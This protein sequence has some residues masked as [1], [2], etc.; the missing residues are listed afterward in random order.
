MLLMKFYISLL[1]IFGLLAFS[2]FAVIGGDNLAHA[3]SHTPTVSINSTTVTSPTN[4]DPI[5]FIVRFSESITGFDATDITRSSGTVQDFGSN[6]YLTAF[7]VSPNLRPYNVA[8][9]STDHVYTLTVGVRGTIMDVFDSDD[10]R[11]LP[12]SIIKSYGTAADQL[13]LPRSML[14]D[15]DGDIYIT[16][17]LNARVQ[18]FNSNFQYLGQFG[19]RGIAEDN[20]RTPDSIAINSTGHIFVT[21]F[22]R[23]LVNIFT[24]N[25]NGGLY[26]GKIGG[27]GNG[28]ATGE[29]NGPRGI[30]IDSDDIIYIADSINDRVQIFNSDGTYQKSIGGA[31]DSIAD[32]E[33]NAPIGIALDS[34]NNIYVT[35]LINDRIQVFNSDG[36]YQKKI[37]GVGSS[38]ILGEFVD[39]RGI[40]V[41]SDGDVY[42]A[43]SRNERFQKLSQTPTRYTFD[44]AGPTDQETLTVSIPAGAAQDTD[45]NDN[46]ISNVISLD[47][48]RTAPTVSSAVTTS[49][50][51]VVLTVSESVSGTRI[52]A[53][54]FVIANVGS[55][56]TV[57]AVV[58][59][60]TTI[61]LTLSAA[62]SE[63]DAAPTVSYTE[64]FRTISDG[65][66]NTI[67]TFPA[68]S[69]TNNIDA[70]IPSVILSSDVSGAT[71]AATISFVATFSEN[72]SGFD[73]SDITI[74]SGTIQNL[75]PASPS[76]PAELRYTFDVVN[77]T[78]QATL[79]VS[80]PA[81]AA[82]DIGPNDSTASNTISLDIDR[83]I[84]T[85]TSATVA[86]P[87]SVILEISESV[88]G[89]N[90]TPGDF[91]ISG[92]TTPTIVSA[93]DITG[94]TITLTLS[95]AIISSDLPTLS[96]TATS[97]PI[98]DAA[99][100]ALAAFS[101]Q[102]ITN[103]LDT[104]AP[105]I[106]SA[107]VTTQTSVTL[108]VSESVSGTNV[109]PGDFTISS[110][111]TPTV[112]SGVDIT[113][114]TITLTLSVAIAD[115]D[116]PTVSY[117]PTSNPISDVAR[118]TLA[119]FS[120]QSVTNDLDTTAPAV[121]SVYP[122]GESS[123]EIMITEPVIAVGTV[124]P[125]S[126]VVTGINPPLTVTAVNFT[127]DTGRIITLTLSAPLVMPDGGGVLL[128]YTA[129]ANSVI[130]DI[131][132]NRFAS[133]SDTAV[134]T[135]PIITLESATTNPTNV[136]PIPF[137]ARVNKAVAGFSAGDITVSGVDSQQQY[138]HLQTIGTTGVPGTA[139]GQFRNPR[140]IMQ[141]SDGNI[142]V[143][144]RS[145]HRIQIFD[146]DTGQYVAKFGSSGS[147][148]GQLHLPSDIIQHTNSNIYVTDSGNDRVQV[149]DGTTHA[150]IS[151]FGSSGIQ[152]GEFSNPGRI[153]QHTNGN[154][155]VTDFEANRVQIFNGTTH[156]YISQFGSMGSANGQFNTP[157][158]IKQHP[159]GN[160]YIVDINNDR[161]QIF[162]GTTHAYISQ[163]GSVGSADGEF[164]A[165]A[166]ILHNSDGD[167]YV[168]DG[169]NHNIQVFDGT[170]H[171]YKDQFGSSGSEDGQFNFPIAMIQHTN[172]NIYVTGF[173]SHRVQIFTGSAGTVQNFTTTINV[174]PLLELR[175]ETIANGGGGVFNGPQQ[176]AL[177]SAG[178][179]YVPDEDNDQIQIFDA[180]GVF[181]NSF[182]ES[183][184][185]DGQFTTPSAVAVNS[186]GH[187][188]VSDRGS[189]SNVQIFYNNG[190][191]I[192][193]LEG[194]NSP[195][196]ITIG[197]NDTIYASNTGD[198]SIRIFDSN[199]VFDREFGVQGDADGE[200]DFPRGIAVNSTGHI[201]VS[202]SDNDRIQVF[203][204]DGTYIRQF[205][206]VG[207][208]SDQFSGPYDIALV[209]VTG[210]IYIADYLNDRI[211]IFDNDGTHIKTFDG[212]DTAGG[213]FDSPR[214]V[215]VNSTTGHVYVSDFGNAVIRVFS[216]SI[217]Y[218]FDVTPSTDPSTITATVSANAVSDDNDD[219]NPASNAVT[220]H[221]DSTLDLTPPTPDSAYIIDA[222]T[223]GLEI[224]EP[225]SGSNPSPSDFVVS[226]VSSNPV[227][228]TTDI[229]D[230]SSIIT[231]TLSGEITDNDLTA[232]LSYT[233]NPNNLITDPSLNPLASF[234]DIG[235]GRPPLV[236]L[237]T[238]GDISSP[239][240]L[241]TIP[242][243]AQFS[244]NITGFE[245]SDITISSGDV[246]NFTLGDVLDHI[247]NIGA[248]AGSAD[249]QFNSPKG[250]MQHSNGDIY[251]SDGRNARV[252]IFDGETGQYVGKFGSQ[253]SEDGEFDF[254]DDIIQ[255][256]N[257]N[258]YVVDP[259]LT[260]I[261]IFNG[262]TH[263][264]ISQF[265]SSGGS[266]GQFDTLSDIMQHSNGNIY[267]VASEQ[268]HVQIFN[269]TTHAYISQF[270]GFGSGD[271]QFKGIN[272]LMQ[273]SNGNIYVAD[274]NNHRVQIFNGTTHAYISQFGSQ[275]SEDG[276]FNFI[277]SIMQHSNGNI[278][279]ADINN[280]N[281]QIF[282]GTTHAYISQ[283]GSQ[284]SEDG[285]FS[286]PIDVIQHSNGD[287]YVVDENNHRVQIFS[288]LSAYNFEVARPTPQETLTV[289]I[290]AD[291][292]QS[293]DDNMTG[294]T[295]SNTISID[296]DTLAPTV[297]S[298]VT[299]IG[300][301][302]ITLE[303]SEPLIEAT[304]IPPADFVI[305]G[306]DVVPTV[307]A[308]SIQDTAITLTLSNPLSTP[309]NTFVLAFNSTDSSI[310]I[311][312]IA[313]NSM[314]LF[315]AI[316]VGTPVVVSLTTN[317]TSPTALDLVPFVAQFSEN[318]I[319]FNVT[320]ITN[321]SGTVQNFAP[322]DPNIKTI[323]SANS[324][325]FSYNRGI[326]FDSAGNLYV[327]DSV[328]RR[329]VVF[330]GDGT[331]L[332]EISM[333]GHV[334]GLALNSTGH[335]FASVGAPAHNVLVYHNNGT[336]IKQFGSLNCPGGGDNCI[337]FSF[338]EG[339]L[340]VDDNDNLYAVDN[341]NDRVQVFDNN[342]AYL[343]Q[344]G[345]GGSGDGQFSFPTGITLDSTG[346][347]YVSDGLGDDIQV[348]YNNGTFIR[349][350]GSSGIGNGQFDFPN[351]I[352][353]GADGRV[354]IA[355]T[356]NH[357]I[358]VFDSQD[359]HLA[360][361]TFA[362]PGVEFVG[363]RGV[364][365]DA[366]N[367]LYIT[368]PSS[369]RV[370][371]FSPAHANAYTFDVANPNNGETLTVDIPA[372][373]AQNANSVDN[374]ASNTVSISIDRTTPIVTSGSIID[375]STLQLV[376]SEFVFANNVTPGDFT[377]TGVRGGNPTV[378]QVAII[379]NNTGTV[380]LTVSPSLSD[381]D[382]RL[383]V[384][385]TQGTNRIADAA[386]NPLASFSNQVVTHPDLINSGGSSSG[387]STSP[388][389]TTSFDDGFESIMI[390][391]VGISPAKF[392][393][394]Y[395]Q[396]TPI[397]VGTTGV[398][399]IQITLHDNL[400][401]N[402]ISHVEMC[403]NKPV[404]NNQICD[405]DTKITWDQSQGDN[406]LDITDPHN[407][408]N[409]G[410]T[411]VRMTEV[412][413]NVATFDFD[414]QFTGVMDGN[415]ISDL[416][417]YAWDTSRNALAFTIENAFEI[418]LGSSSNSNTG[419]SGGSSSNSNTGSS[420]SN[421]NDGTDTSS[422][423]NT[424]TDS[425]TPATSANTGT[426]D[427]TTTPKTS[428]STD[429]NTTTTSNDN[430]TSSSSTLDREVLKRWTGFANESISD[431]E[432]LTHAGISEKSNSSVSQED[433]VL[434]SWTKNLVG[435]WALQGKISTDELKATLSYMYKL[436]SDEK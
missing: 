342:G 141:H 281:V 335:I 72:V 151:Q 259:N 14:V 168:S 350:L 66:G 323:T 33:F 201:F 333:G 371:I 32:G 225:L 167:I 222:T 264:Y 154:I 91:T 292:V 183:G 6:N 426:D 411:S 357:R 113:G 97:G 428:T 173:N 94:S 220:V 45:T 206:G 137:V 242:F 88:S 73:T 368:E 270:G 236:T 279:V 28:T 145:N 315:S 283:F 125:G 63:S 100:N 212:S 354:Y 365:I 284:G 385:Y 273:H 310:N 108:T 392:K 184:T 132:G 162:N 114:S 334:L 36:T 328:N 302:T 56:P 425:S 121:L 297:T 271:G 295:A 395:Q 308:V 18:K 109:T 387:E 424:R 223:V 17:T 219:G 23:D 238:V 265:G 42:V 35:E 12:Q 253:G 258:I 89:T 256:S 75:I 189:N 26:F 260:R 180:N 231:L 98:S 263:A 9:N 329:V 217:V 241:D 229:P 410:S 69:I 419:S 155:Y 150:Y 361:F 321:S 38:R 39:P 268:N 153:M 343:R 131:A 418:V 233:A 351:D 245:E 19:V 8:I 126:F 86:I 41:A 291:A 93:V 337:R 207:S 175:G 301:S 190:T 358:Q 275:G 122:Q 77:S 406:S 52:A 407:I 7:R 416:Q 187:I 192:K 55:S 124:S 140:A 215:A 378:T 359:N 112:V 364:V 221:Y 372:A 1:L 400:S 67:A 317:A 170:T 381:S 5:S 303:A 339:S 429:D 286:S 133:F 290:Q 228:I 209:P 289:S 373:A 403:I 20:F 188:F 374:I 427:S 422:T 34:D 412:N 74:S 269:G 251:V 227:V 340:A 144:D 379:N 261:S 404:T 182:G 327:T 305:S 127:G 70:T 78:D 421:N 247:Q 110:V 414:I 47:I 296:I 346:K 21:D 338:V 51:T 147:G 62:I 160:I 142:Y 163:F 360:T 166:D 54:D 48:D 402:H 90:V 123:I 128:S 31:A 135:F 172:G 195:E 96:Y 46:S 375:M 397:S 185:N 105:T 64:S 15:S 319:G 50:T 316:H 186:T 382:V 176:I 398:T 60:G 415:G 369:N 68:L 197:P 288:T 129:G 405:S 313:G 208:G 158:S 65:A 255:A 386:T 205:G 370:R 413:A 202:D 345:S 218:S 44:I 349:K 294:N 355:D 99:G 71:S 130:N 81:G 213:M 299:G 119:A 4:D 198:S 210:H 363:P 224:S 16:D 30:V 330:D 165:P 352:A 24:A 367:N 244:K 436:T 435:K 298:A 366:D 25:G 432:F 196:G 118:N 204:N 214:G 111:T 143:V 293:D 95:V 193:K 380:A 311:T 332:R 148:N 384:S 267:A 29:F 84:P 314:A 234:D 216:T 146:G 248:G 87:T 152:D 285:E 177:D 389:L 336:F 433:L 161:V 254:V 138:E 107:A 2:G 348:F 13:R 246:Q 306:D 174:T 272:A 377:I 376:L 80:I 82:Q 393:T 347:V 103:S 277:S 59:S 120:S 40:A 43:D 159:N 61:T 417:I 390:D 194:F 164:N 199:G 320:D 178:N 157:S 326:D 11:V 191:F 149:F 3:T 243:I 101:A 27:V 85:V 252:Q 420:S 278:Y 239:T 356:S 353:I 344:I 104:T 280:H 274:I 134:S 394:S 423:G 200:L 434:P 58:V 139:D 383:F 282:N 287:I 76:P 57:A 49:A 249:G 211:Q 266:E 83:S 22:D 430:T 341:G 232:A 179:L 136:S 391:G 230:G 79:T 226:N 116:T 309:I 388:S 156:A 431:A 362:A 117:A 322:S 92:V 102:N 262:T 169:S 276:E 318:V 396:N 240:N 237:S 325:D 171:A 304:N 401:W 312:D 399:Q 203:H 409:D 53:T 115:S 408:I 324:I 307:T 181:L 37:S 235:I 10:R 257:G 331:Y 250:I 300:T 106:S